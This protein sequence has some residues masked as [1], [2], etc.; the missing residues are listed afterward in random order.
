MILSDMIIILYKQE[1]LVLLH[2]IRSDTIAQIAKKFISSMTPI[3]TLSSRVDGLEAVTNEGQACIVS[4]LWDLLSRSWALLIIKEL[5]SVEV[6]RF[7]ELKKRMPG[8]TAATLSERLKDLDAEGIITRKIYPE[9]PPRV[10]YSL[11]QDGKELSAIICQLDRWAR[12]RT[13][14]QSKPAQTPNQLG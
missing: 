7:N 11:T 1:V 8:L 14:L 9:I 4:P 5:S 12:N 10:E 6:I 3:P 2:S 13:N